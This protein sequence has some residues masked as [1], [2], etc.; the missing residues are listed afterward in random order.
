MSTKLLSPDR[1]FKRFDLNFN[2]SIS[3]DPKLVASEASFRFYCYII[4]SLQ[5]WQYD[6]NPLD[7][8]FEKS[9]RVPD[10]LQTRINLVKPEWM[11]SLF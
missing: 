6:L 2:R 9:A 5:I 7:H 1:V 10:A 8:F 3:H 11:A 4:Q